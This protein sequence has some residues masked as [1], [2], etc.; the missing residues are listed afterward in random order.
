MSIQHKL[1][2]PE[3]GI[4]QK[5]YPECFDDYQIYA[6]VAATS[7]GS[8][9][10]GSMV[11]GR[12]SQLCLAL[13]FLLQLLICAAAAAPATDDEDNSFKD[14]SKSISKISSWTKDQQFSRNLLNFCHQIEAGGL[15]NYQLLTACHQK[16]AIIVGLLPLLRHSVLSNYSV[17]NSQCDFVVELNSY[18]QAL[19]FVLH[20]DL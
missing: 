2:S 4:H 20:F 17:L 12:S 18:Y 6:T 9:R 13:P 15:S 7:D 10:K 1:E 5:D 16:E 11:E 19:H 14:S 8:L 3:S